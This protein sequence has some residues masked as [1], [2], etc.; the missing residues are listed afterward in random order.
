MASWGDVDKIT[1]S[2]LYPELDSCA[3]FQLP[4]G[5][6][7]LSLYRWFEGGALAPTQPPFSV[8]ST[9][10]TCRSLGLLGRQWV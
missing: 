9:I 10:E 8:F 7:I 5:Q 1:H 2:C 4:F 3:Q 6:R